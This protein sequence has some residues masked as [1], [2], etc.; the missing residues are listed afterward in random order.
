[1]SLFFSPAPAFLERKITIFLSC[2]SD[3]VDEHVFS[4][5]KAKAVTCACACVCFCSSIFLC[6]R[7]SLEVILIKGYYAAVEKSK[8]KKNGK[9]WNLT[10]QLTALIIQLINEW[11]NTQCLPIYHF[12]YYHI[13]YLGYM[14][15]YSN[16]TE[17]LSS[18]PILCMHFSCAFFSFLESWENVYCHGNT[19]TYSKWIKDTASEFSA[20]RLYICLYACVQRFFLGR[21]WRDQIIFYRVLDLFSSPSSVSW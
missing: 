4:K 10:V 2:S 5:A 7:N 16:E 1:M 13:L 15:V 17:K 21:V 6:L 14:D 11:V 9:K 19:W 8:P 3:P 12:V 20:T 18:A